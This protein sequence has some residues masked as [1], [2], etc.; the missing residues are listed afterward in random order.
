MQ[1]PTD[2]LCTLAEDTLNK[3]PATKFT[4]GA[5]MQTIQTVLNEFFETYNPTPAK[6]N[7]TPVKVNPTRTSASRS[8]TSGSGTKDKKTSWSNVHTRKEIGLTSYFPAVLKQIKAD[9]PK[10]DHFT[11]ISLMRDTLETPEYSAE[12]K[13]Y[14]DTIRKAHP[15]L[16]LPDMCPP[17]VKKTT[18][19]SII[20]E[21]VTSKKN[22]KVPP[23]DSSSDNDE[24]IGDLLN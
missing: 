22:T 10:A 18:P 8:K 12:W 3:I 19:T 6:V 21:P 13:Q 5:V 20:V 2:Q 16:G 9:H 11:L 24:E 4:R 17:R 23:V 14:H 1:T 7:P 15:E